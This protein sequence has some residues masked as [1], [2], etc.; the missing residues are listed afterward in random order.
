LCLL[1]SC[2]IAA[3]GQLANVA[4]VKAGP[5]GDMVIG[6]PTPY[7]YKINIAN[8]GPDNAQ[9]VVI[10]DLVPAQFVIT[11]VQ[12]TISPG[13]GLAITCNVTGQLVL[14][15]TPTLFAGG[16]G[17]VTINVTVPIT[18][19]PFT[20]NN[21]ATVT[22]STPNPDPSALRSSAIN[23]VILSADMT[24][25]IDGPSNVLAGDQ[26][27]LTLAV[28]TTNLGYSNA[29]SDFTW[30]QVPDPL[31][32]RGV[33]D[34]RCV[35]VACNPSI[36]VCAPAFPNF[37]GQAVRC[38]FGTVVP[39]QT[40]NIRIDLTVP[41][42]TLL[43]TN[44]GNL[45]VVAF[46]NSTTHDPNYLNNIDVHTIRI[47]VSANLAITKGS[48]PIVTAG[49]GPYFLYTMIVQ[50]AG[51]SDA[52]NVTLTDPLLF[53][54]VCTSAS[55]SCSVTPTGSR[56]IAKSDLASLA[57]R[58]GAP[59]L[60]TPTC[61]IN[62]NQVLSCFTP[63]LGLFERILVLVNCSTPS[64]A[65]PQ[66][67]VFPWFVTNTGSVSTPT[68]Q[69]DTSRN[70]NSAVTQIILNSDVSVR[71]FGPSS[72]VVAGDGV[73]YNW[74]IS[75]TNNGPSTAYGVTLNDTV[76]GPIVVNGQPTVP[77]GAGSCFNTNNFVS[78]TLNNLLSG[79]T[80]NITVPFN[81]PAN[82]ATTLVENCATAYVTL[83]DTNTNNNRGCAE[84]LVLAAPFVQITKTGPA[85]IT[86]DNSNT[87]YYYT[88]IVNNQG[89]SVALNGVVTDALPSP[90][91]VAG[92]ANTTQGACQTNFA[93]NNFFCN[94]GA[95]QPNVVVTVIVP[96][97]VPRNS[98]AVNV[99]NTAFVSTSTPNRNPVPQANSSTVLIRRSDLAVTKQGF[100]PVCAGDQTAV[101][102]PFFTLIVTNNGPTD[103]V[104]VSLTDT[105]PTELQLGRLAG[106]LPWTI[107]GNQ[108]AASC[109]LTNTVLTCDLGSLAVG[110]S[111]TVQLYYFVLPSQPVATVINNVTVTSAFEDQNNLGNNFALFP[112]TICNSAD[113]SIVKTSASSTIVAGG[114]VGNAWIVT[115]TNN[116]PSDARSVI[117]VDVLPSVFTYGQPS[118]GACGVTG[119]VLTC[120]YPYFARGTVQTF[121]IPF[122]AAATLPGGPVQNCVNVSSSVT[123]DPNPQN[124][125]NCTV[126]Q[127]VPQATLS[128]VKTSPGTQCAGTTFPGTFRIVVTNLGPSVAQSVT[129]TD[130]GNA[131]FTPAGPITLT[132]TSGNCTWDNN[133][134]G[135]GLSC[136]LGTFGL[137][138][139]TITYPVLV[140]FSVGPQTAAPNTATVQWFVSGNSNAL[141]ASSTA[142]TDICNYVDFV[143]Q[144]TCPA[145]VSAGGNG[146]FNIVATN[147]GPANAQNVVI[148]DPL[149]SVFNYGAGIVP[150]AGGSCDPLGV[151]KVLV[152]RWPTV[153]RGATISVT[154]PF[155]VPADI[156]QQ[157]PVQNCAIVSTT[158]N[159]TGP[160]Q[161]CCNTPIQ[162][163]TTLVIQKTGPNRVCAG[164]PGFFFSVTVTNNGPAVANNVNVTD[165]LNGAV[166]TPWN[167]TSLPS[168]CSFVNQQ[169]TCNL[170]TLTVG[171]S[172]SFQYGAIVLSSVPAQNQ[173]PNTA[174]LTTST[175]NN[176]NPSST[177]F[178]D[179]CNNA[180]LAITKSVSN[181]VTAGSGSAVW[182]LGITN[183]GQSDA[184]VVTVSDVLPADLT[185]SGVTLASGPA[186]NCTLTNNVVT[187][188][189]PYFARRANAVVFVT[190]SANQALAT[191]PRVNCANVSSSVTPDDVP[192]NNR[193]C[194]TVFV[195]AQATV[196]I[197]KT[198]PGTVCAGTGIVGLFT[199]T[200]QNLGPSQVTTATLS[201]PLNPLFT[202]SLPNLTQSTT[203]FGTCSWV[204]S[205]AQVV[206]NFN[207]LPVGQAITVFYG[208]TVE[209]N[210]PVTF[211]V[212]NVATVQWSVS[213]S[214]QAQ[215]AQ[216]QANTNICNN[217]VLALTKEVPLNVS[218]G[219]S[220]Y[221]YTI[222]VTN[223]GPAVARN[224]VI[225]DSLP[226]VFTYGTP[227]ASNGGNCTINPLTLLL[228]CTWPANQVLPV[229]RQWQI[230]IPFAV[231]SSI[232]PTTSTVE[233]CALATADLASPVRACA[234][235]YVSIA[236]ALVVI[237]NGPTLVCAGG[238]QFT[239]NITVI[240]QGPAD[241]RDV[242]VVDT[243]NTAVYTP[244]TTQP[245]LT[246][247][248]GSLPN[249]G[250]CAYFGNVL[251]CT[252]GLVPVGTQ[253]I[254]TYPVTVA[255]SVPAQ[256]DVPNTAVIST[257]T[258]GSS[259][260]TSTHLTDI[261]NTADLDVTK[262][263]SSSSA[264]A[265]DNVQRVYTITVRNNGISDARSVTMTDAFPA[266]FT[267][268]G[269]VTWNGTGTCTVDTNT[270]V[271]TC[272]W[273][274]QSVG[275]VYVVQ[276]PFKV[277]ATVPAGQ[278]ENCAAVIANPN[279]DPDPSNNRRCVIVTVTT[280]SDV[281]VQ[282]T[283]PTAG[284]PGGVTAGDGV[285]YNYVVTVGN[286]GPSVA[287]NAYFIDTL[288][289][290]QVRLVGNLPSGCFFV[291]VTQ[292]RCEFGTL[293]VNGAPV[294]RTFGF[295]VDASV[296]DRQA[297]NAVQVF[298]DSNVAGA[299]ND[300]ASVNTT[301]CRSAP[302][303]I[304]KT[305]SA[306]VLAGDPNGGQF[307][308]AVSNPGPSTSFNVLVI[309]TSL[310]QDILGTQV[311][312]TGIS[313]RLG[314]PCNS[315]S[316]SC[317]Y[318]FMLPFQND[319]I[320]ITFT[321][322]AS[323]I[324]GVY[325][326]C[327]TISSNSPTAFARSCTPI[328]IIA[329]A[330]L[331]TTKTGP[332]SAIAG[333]PS[334][335]NVFLLSVTNIGGSDAQNVVLSDPLPSPLVVTGTSRPG[336]CSVNTQNN[337]V[338]CSVGT[339]APN[340]VFTVNVFF[341]VPS[342]A[343]LTN[344]TNTACA[345]T[346]T[347]LRPNGGPLCAS[348]SVLILCQVSL[349]ISKTDGVTQVTAGSPNV[350]TFN[351]TVSNGGPTQARDVIVNDVWPSQFYT[352][353]GRPQ[354]SQ[355]FCIDTS[356]GYQCSLG[357]INS[358]ASANIFISYTVGPSVTVPSVTNEACVVSSCTQ[359]PPINPN[360]AT[361]VNRIVTAADL[362]TI[363]DDCVSQVFAG[364]TSGYIF[365]ISTTNLGPSDAQNVTVS[366]QWPSVYAQTPTSF[367]TIP[368]A[369]CAF[370]PGG[371]FS[372]NF[373]TVAYGATVKILVGYTVPGTTPPGFATNCAAASSSTSDP[374][375]LNSEDCDTNEIIAQA[376]LVITKSI[377]SDQCV[378]A[379][380]LTQRT[381]IVTVTNNGPATAQSPVVTDNIPAGLQ[382]ITEPAGCTRVGNNYTCFLPTL[383]KGQF[384][385]LRWT[386]IV[387]AN[388]VPGL[389]Q[390][391]ANVTSVT[392]DPEKCNN[393]F[394]ICSQICAESDLIIRKTDNVEVVTAG[395][396][397]QYVYTVSGFNA[398][399]SDAY[400]VI[401]EDVWPA[402]FVRGLI[403]APGGN[404]TQQGKNFYV[405][406]PRVPVNTGVTFTVNYTVPECLL[407]CEE[408]NA[409]SIRSDNRD[410]NSVSN[411]AQDCT[412][413]RTEADV[414]L[415]KNDNVT[416]IVAGD[417]ITYI[418]TVQVTNYG[419]SC[420]QEVRL[421]DTFPR[422][423]FQIPGSISVTQGTCINV[424]GQDI[425]CNLQTIQPGQIVTMFVS[426]T[427]PANASTCSVTNIVVASSPTWDPELCNNE[428]KD[429]NALL[430]QSQLLVT[431]TDGL[432]NITATDLS[433]KTYNIVVTNLGPST[434]RD[435]MLTDRWPAQFTQFLRSIKI[436]QGACVSTGFD[437]TCLSGDLPKGSSITLQVD[438]TINLP[439]VCGPV[440]NVI[441]AFS[442][443]DTTCRDA[444]DTTTIINCP[445][446]PV[447][448]GVECVNC[449]IAATQN[450]SGVCN[451]EY[452]NSCL[453]NVN[454][455]ACIASVL[456][457][458][459]SPLPICFSDQTACS[460]MQCI[461]NGVCHGPVGQGG[462]CNSPEQVDVVCPAQPLTPPVGPVLPVGST[463][464]QVLAGGG[465]LACPFTNSF[466]D[467]VIQNRG[468]NAAGSVSLTATL[469][470]GLSPVSTSLFSSATGSCSITSAQQVTC[471]FGRLSTYPAQVRVRILFTAF[472]AS[473]G[474]RISSTFVITSNEQT[475]P[476]L[477][478][479]GTITSVQ[480]PSRRTLRG[481]EIV[482]R[483]DVVV[484]DVPAVAQEHARG[485]GAQLSPK[486]MQLEVTKLSAK[487]FTVSLRNTL[488]RS[489]T[490]Q[491]LTMQ[492]FLDGRMREVSLTSKS[493]VAGVHSS[494]CSVIVDRVLQTSWNVQCDVE[495][496]SNVDLASAVVV[497]KGF[498]QATNGW[499]PV[500]GSFR[501]QKN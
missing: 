3:S 211:N 89:P 138:S 76:P 67:G 278:V 250:T 344:V 132:G 474:Q 382:I 406:Y 495:M 367:Q 109:Q 193:A 414:A 143:I 77:Q 354:P 373:G 113:L 52:A 69:R 445:A 247:I 82:A 371:F 329:Q 163:A 30:V 443:T 408:C 437:F 483:S 208:V 269:P 235:T 91:V 282:K 457:D 430:E 145:S 110:N 142:F 47:E 19:Q 266:L 419:P 88:I 116:G 388:R 260:R 151:D 292:V 346:T 162:I 222:R 14:C 359:V 219:S 102:Q 107:S 38:D 74:I 234:T 43:G 491:D 165:L 421:V 220:G 182:Q 384:V 283:G 121:S 28:T 179:I 176:G 352:I 438:Y 33:S 31:I 315:T 368:P 227:T 413:V 150:S 285:T 337:T 4:I 181:N 453:P 298:A 172:V 32:F 133:G 324:P 420:A 59:C 467:V 268:D 7:Q 468:P 501:F 223:N 325:E 129:V 333:L 212:P 117:V 50:N 157:P 216:A 331:V 174:T 281:W 383:N 16:T 256:N 370:A 496:A 158:T 361:D 444:S 304:V 148:R 409:V 252:L 464:L 37:V 287:T 387:P 202:P 471:N 119:N 152:C 228:T 8:A 305:G 23:N 185:Y 310:L 375:P 465:T 451:P 92:Q 159:S 312:V 226:G 415:C 68:F 273:A 246:V 35:L 353:Q 494:T 13:G 178:T 472:S 449:A 244:G 225:T 402:G 232:P 433:R 115:V 362:Y 441:S 84:V 463:S 399:P 98:P 25:N 470:N 340:A 137:G 65:Y 44:G 400:N 131:V 478:V 309:D 11:S 455:S 498:A 423:V 405:T 456:R 5:P 190:F 79:Q 294:T 364:E 432:V 63:Q 126:V 97:T 146:Q 395:D 277:D 286:F 318:D 454:C 401:I 307:T 332:A 489:V 385:T 210:V 160:W 245:T 114:Q 452:V 327:A 481:E 447:A 330:N 291:T 335:N 73:T 274:Y 12:P 167:Q 168:F 95:L 397:V 204:G 206:C 276:V 45:T 316:L 475:T 369:A 289:L 350:I 48:I 348:A 280:L 175:P 386:F 407:E 215:S 321:A 218:S 1:A 440:T 100:S 103:A 345:S 271:I 288:P 80:V 484:R 357:L 177:H 156:A 466:F 336:E 435:V 203:A 376:D 191:G 20:A 85:N 171:Q 404:V 275:T 106:G 493:V 153:V 258:P 488:R 149:P 195:F 139:A 166:F 254:I 349:S 209:A 461:Y 428:A 436:S 442:P 297:T 21:T 390:N 485:V 221:Q 66:N 56:S 255:A 229:N 328:Q 263:V 450:P 480:C 75:V 200:I 366:D 199:V 187:C 360:C 242:F 231:P 462:P 71:K 355:G 26:Q 347:P 17:Q 6:F 477:G 497:V 301:I 61:S 64:T 18:T 112:V 136:T 29:S 2:L 105:S 57:K 42:F 338:R 284:C 396:K 127:V 134:A 422:Q 267:F 427:V 164:D 128:I 270:K 46:T 412:K 439:A 99:T 326:N 490:V 81:A 389:I 238:P 356:N 155:T 111:I 425:S 41:G 9:D 251:N 500:M 161:S 482:E 87:L 473:L 101:N 343:A 429:V 249:P 351:I 39:G 173:V 372:C 135:P 123:S 22:S 334:A 86:V 378:V 96:F 341:S 448:P 51:L 426:Y 237:K 417:G 239:F 365:T 476:S 264:I 213:G 391:C 486:I 183:N 94:L 296:R 154:V 358:G 492:L 339:L 257:S 62:A 118:S 236:T 122:T 192:D 299:T 261:C 205:P 379:G 317:S 381:Y 303:T 207:N 411:T 300:F 196:I 265:G 410:P 380:S 104:G 49:T 194:A 393:G 272:S 322:S 54:F 186:G 424:N 418:Y 499:N 293:P 201:D 308:L 120:S 295:T 217:V 70:I 34:N 130:S 374:N 479:A 459:T 60:L 311:T 169:L 392:P 416:S 93:G 241:A 460:M 398:G 125:V 342:D 184:R 55:A 197:G 323:A 224:V 230:F 446:P 302:L 124:N 24:V 27:N 320:T 140:P 180:D 253:V 290:G 141:T 40:I 243:L 36:P 248:A 15:V 458:P 279:T 58:E 170:G 189:F 83:N 469:G 259:P 188:T 394:C 487:S 363:K 198:S 262:T 240:N 78:C 233:N 90:F 108:T 10:R 144:K 403:D 306:S 319:T 147:N 214:T 313:S 431:K 314:V 53:P 434:A 72:S 377:D